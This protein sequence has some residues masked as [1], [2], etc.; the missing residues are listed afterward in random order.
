M[1]RFDQF[2]TLKNDL[3]NQNFEM[4]KVVHNFGKFDGDIIW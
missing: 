2:S 1:E 4:F 3:E